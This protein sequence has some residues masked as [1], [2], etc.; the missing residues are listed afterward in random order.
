MGKSSCNVHNVKEIR[1]IAIDN[2]IQVTKVV[3]NR[4]IYKSK[5]ELCKE[6]GFQHNIIPEIKTPSY[7]KHRDVADMILCGNCDVTGI[8]RMIKNGYNINSNEPE[9]PLYYAFMIGNNRIQKLLDLGANINKKRKN[10]NTL[11]HEAAIENLYGRALFLVNKGIN[12]KL[13]NKDNVMA[14]HYAK[15]KKMKD[16]LDPFLLKL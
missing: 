8:K 1:K 9:L 7:G 14:V 13:R 11:L 10:G 4:R 3:G 16:L 5:I 6:L 2:N 12:K 15:T